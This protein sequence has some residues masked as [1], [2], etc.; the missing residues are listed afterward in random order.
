[1]ARRKRYMVRKMMWALIMMLAIVM[2]LAAGAAWAATKNTDTGRYVFQDYETLKPG[3]FILDVKTRRYVDSGY[4]AYMGGLKA[5]E[6]GIVKA[7]ADAARGMGYVRTGLL[8]GLPSPGYGIEVGNARGVA[9]TAGDAWA[10]GKKQNSP[11]GCAAL[12]EFYSVPYSVR[13]MPAGPALT[14]VTSAFYGFNRRLDFF[15]GSGLQQSL[16]GNMAMSR[17]TGAHVFVFL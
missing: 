3:L 4:A 8:Y 7:A 13:N 12:A 1:M 6:P 14:M 11:W 15:T 16:L 5:Q 17:D 2:V 9:W 10:L